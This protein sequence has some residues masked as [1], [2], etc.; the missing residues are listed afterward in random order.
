MVYFTLSN[1][2]KRINKKNHKPNRD[3][4]VIY[5]NQSRTFYV[6]VN[7]EINS[8]GANPWLKSEQQ[9]IK[10]ELDTKGKPFNAQRNPETQWKRKTL[11]ESKLTIKAGRPLRCICDFIS[12]RK[13]KLSGIGRVL[14]WHVFI[15]ISY[16]FNIY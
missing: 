3:T 4:I 8:T 11:N 2:V 7:N 10:A 5:R 12:R 6:N 16:P 14:E 9:E 13:H 1:G 15:T